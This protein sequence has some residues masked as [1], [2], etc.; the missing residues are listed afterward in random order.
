VEEGKE[1]NIVS[2]AREIEVGDVR[3]SRGTLG[4]WE[5]II[6]YA[7][8]SDGRFRFV[9]ARLEHRKDSASPRL[10]A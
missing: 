6:R 2:R 4:V 7:R 3:R 10:R 5:A 1:E 8:H 9:L